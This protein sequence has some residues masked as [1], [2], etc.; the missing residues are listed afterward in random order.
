MRNKYKTK[1]CI[2]L[3]NESNSLCTSYNQFCVISDKKV[4]LHDI[5]IFLLLECTFPKLAGKFCNFSSL[6]Y[7]CLGS[8]HT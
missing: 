6:K 7:S 5:F 1:Y 3:A 8:C 4:K 2:S